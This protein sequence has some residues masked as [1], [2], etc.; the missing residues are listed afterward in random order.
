MPATHRRPAAA[1]DRGPERRGRLAEVRS[2]QL[3][4]DATQAF[5]DAALADRLVAIAE[6]SLQQAEATLA[7]V[8]LAY[9]PAVR[10]SSTRCG[11]VWRATTSVPT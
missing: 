1:G 7:Q 8:E 6:A 9:R 5:Y 11:P 10:P 4:S 3:C 2:R